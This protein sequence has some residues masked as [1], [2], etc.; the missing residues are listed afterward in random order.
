MQN[1][2]IAVTGGIG[3]GKSAVCKIIAE[4]GYKVFSC[5]K[6]YGELLSEPAFVQ[7][8]KNAFPEAIVGGQIDKRALAAAVFA[9]R[10]K[11]K[12]LD[13][14]TFP[15]I[16]G[17]AHKLLE[18]QKIGFLEV[19]LLFEGGFERDFDEVWVVTRPKKARIAAVTE[20]SGLTE[21][22]VAAR[23]NSQFDYDGADLS[24]YRVIENCGNMEDLQRAVEGALKGI[25]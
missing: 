19:P 9:D 20:R 2:K 25:Q 21:E 24:G 7:K 8:L 13:G 22:E 23:I 15:E 10:E 1:K 18:G 6:I 4:R 17:R 16:M 3:S 5:D 14:L 11:L 12:K